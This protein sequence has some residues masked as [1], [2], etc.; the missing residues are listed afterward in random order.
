MRK[1]INFL[2]KDSQVR[3]KSLDIFSQ[4]DEM[5]STLKWRDLNTEQRQRLWSKYEG[6]QEL[7]KLYRRLQELFDGT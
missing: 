4:I 2:A 1:K 5:L 6:L 3:T 7:R